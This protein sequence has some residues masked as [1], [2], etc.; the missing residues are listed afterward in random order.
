M[1]F[2][3]KIISFYFFIIIIKIYMAI[4][5]FW[6]NIN[7]DTGVL[8]MFFGLSDEL[9]KNIKNQIKNIREHAFINPE[10]C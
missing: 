9:K 3:L 6:F 7:K 1:L 5:I 8:S 4:T 10:D 2:F